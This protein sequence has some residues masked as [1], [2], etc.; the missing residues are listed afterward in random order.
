MATRQ[1]R[2][3]GNWKMN[4]TTNEVNEWIEGL[5][6]LSLTKHCEVGVFP[7]FPYI[8][9]LH[10]SLPNCRVGAQ[11]YYPEEKGAFTGEVS[12]AQIQDLGADMVLVGHSERRIIFGESHALLKRKV[13]FALL[14]NVT[15]VFCCGEPLEIRQKSDEKGFV[16][17]QLEQS[18]FHLDEKQLLNCV[19]AYEPV[20]AIGT[21]MT[22][23]ADQAEDMHATIRMWIA[24]RY[25]RALSESISILYGGSCN[26]DNAL[27]LF[28]CPNVDGG[29]IGGASLK[30]SSFM[31]IMEA[32]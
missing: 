28:S 31:A 29:L 3:Y 9:L 7:G 2:I 27:E 4:L 12:I 5:K 17:D 25:S 18:L 8:Q 11:N 19:I 24:E 23:T 13:D 6:S 16:L 26:A 14:A 30:A 20:W 22:A 21:G 15:P 1:K 32:L 10:E